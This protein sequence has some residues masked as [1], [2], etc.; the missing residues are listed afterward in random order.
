[1]WRTA[2]RQSSTSCMWDMDSSHI[3]QHH[4]NSIQITCV[5][6]SKRF[7]SLTYLTVET[8]TV[9]LLTLSI[10]I[11]PELPTQN[12][13]HLVALIFWWIRKITQNITSFSQ[14]YRVWM[15]RLLTTSW[16]YYKNRIFVNSFIH[17]IHPSVLEVTLNETKAEHTL[18]QSFITL[19]LILP[20]FCTYFCFDC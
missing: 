20:S 7:A 3:S 9:H 10:S 2:D 16:F 1:M 14:F 19:L 13:L 11:R 8:D 12:Q 5:C 6:V 15:W 17:F 18:V 4:T